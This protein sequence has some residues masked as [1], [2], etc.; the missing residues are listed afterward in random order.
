[1]QVK[2]YSIAGEKMSTLV[3]D[4][5]S[6]KFSSE[7]YVSIEKFDEAWSKKLK[8]AKTFEIENGKIIRI[9][10]EEKEAE[11]K[12]SHEGFMS[13]VSSCEFSFNQLHDELEFYKNLEIEKYYTK[14]EQQLSSFKAVKNY[15][16]GLILTIGVSYFCFTQALDL[17]NGILEEHSCNY[18]ARMFYSAIEFLGVKGVILVG[19]AICSSIAYKIYTRFIHPPI[20]TVYSPPLS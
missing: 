10:K 5:L 1:M 6:M 4:S 9:S 12:I 2:M 20:V 17:E 15:C 19:L 14:S 11:L 16:I 13:I 8:L 3:V 7:S 18:K